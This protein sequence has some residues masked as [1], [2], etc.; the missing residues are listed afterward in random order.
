[1]L[2]G[3]RG[4]PNGSSAYLPGAGDEAGGPENLDKSVGEVGPPSKAKLPE[5]APSPPKKGR[6]GARAG[7]LFFAGAS[8]QAIDPAFLMGAS[9]T[10]QLSEEGGL[11]LEFGIDG[12]PAVASEDDRSSGLVF[13][14]G[15]ARWTFGGEPRTCVAAGISGA[16]ES[17]RSDPYD[18]SAASSV[19]L[20]DLG[21]GLLVQRWEV[22][23]GYSIVAGSENVRGLVQITAGVSF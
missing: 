18:L 2:A 13:F 19:M 10:Y 12:V 1:M 11:A 3:T 20:I 15:G 9:Y 7:L 21:A 17:M 8:E 16:L 4:S 14:R 6:F 5:K 22:R 23:A